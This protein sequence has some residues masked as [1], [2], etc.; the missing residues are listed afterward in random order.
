MIDK[1]LFQI[2][3]EEIPDARVA[4]TMTDGRIVWEA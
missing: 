1:N 2:P 4:L 3:P